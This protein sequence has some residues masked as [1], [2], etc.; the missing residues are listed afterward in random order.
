MGPT[1]YQDI[2]LTVGDEEPLPLVLL[3][4]P[5]TTA[6]L[7]FGGMLLRRSSYGVWVE[8]ATGPFT[9][10]AALMPVP[11]GY[12]A[13]TSLADLLNQLWDLPVG[14]EPDARYP[15]LEAARRTGRVMT[16]V[17]GLDVEVRVIRVD[18][19]TG[20]TETQVILAV[21]GDLTAEWS[22][23]CMLVLPVIAVALELLVEYNHIAG[24]I[25]QVFERALTS[26]SRDVVA[27][28]LETVKSVAELAEKA[29]GLIKDLGLA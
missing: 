23:A 1:S 21:P 29:L 19:G 7:D 2:P 12:A 13:I 24:A 22:Q 18:P 10:G 25:A 20:P 8:T 26:Q 4:S 11:G 5:G 6:A 14:R 28:R 27:E 15:H 9:F 3:T 17:N 16:Q